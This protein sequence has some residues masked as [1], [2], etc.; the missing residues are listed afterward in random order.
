MSLSSTNNNV[1]GP[2]VGGK[3]SINLKKI[4]QRGGG[5]FNGTLKI[6]WG[7]AAQC[8]PNIYN[9]L[10]ALTITGTLDTTAR[11]VNLTIRGATYF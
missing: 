9:N 10:D 8:S 11:T 5:A 4:I 2:R 3:S 7:S 1:N 6:D